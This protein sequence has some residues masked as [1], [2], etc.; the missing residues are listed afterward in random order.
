MKMGGRIKFRLDELGWQ[1]RDLI[2]RLPDLV[3][4]E[5]YSC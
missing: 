1:Q 4:L 5:L 2:E 3:A